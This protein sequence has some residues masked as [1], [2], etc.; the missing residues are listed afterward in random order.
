MARA[1][2]AGD[3]PHFFSPGGLGQGGTRLS[4]ARL[5]LEPHACG[6][7]WLTGQH[8]LILDNFMGT[9]SAHEPGIS[10]RC[11][12]RGCT[13]RADRFSDPTSLPLGLRTR[14]R[15]RT[16]LPG[17]Q[18]CTPAE[19]FPLLASADTKRGPLWSPGWGSLCVVASECSGV[20][21]P[22]AKTPGTDPD[23]AGDTSAPALF[24]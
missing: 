14:G 17:P 6:P 23:T 9:A 11:S 13:Q 21:W 10:R 15:D 20:N 4:L 2:P 19:D 1:P 16:G 8:F 7:R 24:S 22:K 5:C 3:C 18:K 12:A